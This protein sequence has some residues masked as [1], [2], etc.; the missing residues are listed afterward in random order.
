MSRI[1]ASIEARMGSSRLPG[2]V[3]ADIGGV[4]AL[5]RLLYRLRLA[6]GVDDIVLA[7]SAAPAD[8]ALEAWARDCGVAVYRSSEDDVLDRVVQ[9]QRMMHFEF[10]AEV[11]GDCP[12]LYPE[13]VSLGIERFVGNE[14]DV[15]TIGKVTTFPQGADIQV[16]RRAVLETVADTL[17]DP[18]VR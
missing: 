3:L 16:D 17:F 4:P 7:T 10:I 5:S 6:R 2:K 14:G 18:A 1:V 12:L 8:D 11:T 9:A 13:V 15:A